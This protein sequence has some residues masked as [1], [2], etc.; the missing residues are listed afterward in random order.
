MT[1]TLPPLIQAFSGAFGGAVA[2]ASV[3]PLDLVGTRLQTAKSKRNQGRNWY[4]IFFAK[5]FNGFNSGITEAVHTLK[6]IVNKKG[7]TG[8]YDGLKT[9]TGA[10]VLSRYPT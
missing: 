5:P 2:N 4:I 8:L 9:D 6:D 10:T 7:A 1:S 3:Y